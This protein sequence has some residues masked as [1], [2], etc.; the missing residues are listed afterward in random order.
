MAVAEGR[1]TGALFFSVF[2]GAWFLLALAYSRHFRWYTAL[3][4]VAGV[5]AF[6]AIAVHLRRLVGEGAK[7][8]Y[9]D[10]EK[11][12]NDNQ[13]FL[14][15]GVTYALVFLLFA[16]LPKVHASNY[17]FPAFVFLVGLH[18]LPM[19]PLYRHRSN[20]VAGLTMM[21]WAVVCVLLFHGN[22]EL[23]AAWVTLGAGLAL[24]ASAAWAL[25]TANELV[26]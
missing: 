10:A 17:V 2:G 5:L 15:N 26:R 11:K 4:V 3:A 6:V 13:F 24:W 19:P 25:R 23:E 18:F 12:A 21:T 22:G 7:N 14:I 9:P 16:I 8:A 1:C 20:T